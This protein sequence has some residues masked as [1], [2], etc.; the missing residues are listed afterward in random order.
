MKI[1]RKFIGGNVSKEAI[2]KIEK[3]RGKLLLKGRGVD[4]QRILEETIMLVDEK[5]VI[6][7]LEKKE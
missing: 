2:Q 5:E 6:K 1:N 4:K 3:I 7:S